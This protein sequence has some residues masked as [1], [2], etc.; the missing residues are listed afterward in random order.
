MI[1]DERGLWLDVLV[2][3]IGYFGV[4]MLYDKRTRGSVHPA[5]FW[6]AGALVAWV[7]ATFVLASLPP[8]VTLAAR[9][10]G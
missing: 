9:L 1:F 8:V 10:A 2:L 4:G 7:S 5:Y 3:M 6:G